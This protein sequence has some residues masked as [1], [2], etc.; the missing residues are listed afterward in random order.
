MTHKKGG[1]EM[2]FDHYRIHM[3]S[4]QHRDLDFPISGKPYII[5]LVQK[6]QI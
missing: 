5:V 4:I 2:R 6:H 3:F 1:I